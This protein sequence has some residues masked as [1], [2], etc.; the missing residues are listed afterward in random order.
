MIPNIPHSGKENLWRQFKK[1]NQQNNSD[2]LKV[3]TGQYAIGK[4][5]RIVGQGTLRYTVDFS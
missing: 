4:T 2:A 5:Y 1:K 3:D